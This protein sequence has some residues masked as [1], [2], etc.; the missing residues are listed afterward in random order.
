MLGTL[1]SP[2]A[3]LLLHGEPPFGWRGFI[4]FVVGVLFLVWLFNE[5]ARREIRS[6]RKY[7]RSSFVDRLLKERPQFKT[8]LRRLISKAG[9]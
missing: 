8:K 9:R 2:F 7:R 1:Y 6:I 4:L 5:M 3:G